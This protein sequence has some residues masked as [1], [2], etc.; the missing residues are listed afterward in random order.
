MSIAPTT[1][2][3]ASEGDADFVRKLKGVLLSRG[4][5]TAEQFES[6]K[7]EA[8][9]A[10]QAAGERPKE[11]PPI[12]EQPRLPSA[13]VHSA[14]AVMAQQQARGSSDTT[15]AA[16]T[17]GTPA[18]EEDYTDTFFAFVE[19][20]QGALV[21]MQI[22]EAWAQYA[23]AEGV[24]EKAAEQAKNS[25]RGADVK[26]LFQLH[27]KLKESIDTAQDS[28]QK[29][30]WAYTYAFKNFCCP[31]KWSMSHLC[32]EQGCF[33]SIFGAACLPCFILCVHP[34][35]EAQKRRELERQQQQQQQ[36]QQ[37]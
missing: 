6:A 30:K 33:C 11:C 8:A 32:R 17:E 34:C 29:G 23:N 15:A 22:E 37:H 36:Q 27:E 21:V 14:P 26:L 10:S 1:E 18:D 31:T 4:L 13:R 3:S 5:L 16:D 25:G 35:F 9:A 19:R 12:A 7:N 24:L 28:L 2:G 20:A